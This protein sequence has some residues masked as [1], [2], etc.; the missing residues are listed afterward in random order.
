MIARAIR[1]ADG[2]RTVRVLLSSRAAEAAKCLAD[3]AMI[4]VFL[5]D[6]A[7]DVRAVRRAAA[8][9]ALVDH[10]Y[11]VPT[12][13]DDDVVVRVLRTELRARAKTAY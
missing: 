8:A 12:H 6:E 2:L 10:C 1:D 11:T 3:P 5:L 7:A 13:H 4:A 9:H